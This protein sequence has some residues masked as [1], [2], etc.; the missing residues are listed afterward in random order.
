MRAEVWRS[1]PLPEAGTDLWEWQDGR[2]AWCG[3]D[4][5]SLVVDHCHMTGLVRGLLCRGCNTRESSSWLPAWEKW[6]NGD[7]PAWALRWFEIYRNQLGAT[8]YSVQSALQ[9]YNPE[10]REAWFILSVRH[11]RAGRMKWPTD[12]PWIDT[13]VERKEAANA[14]MREAMSSWDFLCPTSSSDAAS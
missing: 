11:L 7:N 13:A 1:W 12:A 3:Y 14:Q 4:R 2:C 9:W 8:P 10:E 6:R 5:E